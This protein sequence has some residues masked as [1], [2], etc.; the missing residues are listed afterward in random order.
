M[1]DMADQDP[2]HIIIIGAGLAGL[3]TAVAIKTANPS[4]AV[5]ILETTKSLSEIGAGLQLTPNGTLPKGTHHEAMTVRRYDGSKILNHIHDFQNLILKKYKSPFMGMHRV[6]FQRALADKCEELGVVLRLG[7]RVV[8]VDIESVFVKL[9]GGEVVD[10]DVIVSADGL[11]SL[12]RSVFLK[13]PSPPLP[14][15][16]LAYRIVIG[17]DDLSGDDA[18]ELTEFLRRKETNFWVGPETHVA[19]Y[20]VRDGTQYNIVLLCPD[21]LPEGI[22]KLDGDLVEMMGRFDG[23]D[24]I[25]RKFLGQVKRVQKWKLMHLDPLPEWTNKEGTFVMVGDACHPMLP[26]LAQ[27]ANSACEDAAVLGFLLGQVRSSTVEGKQ[28]MLQKVLPLYE[29]LRKTRGEGIVRATWDQREDFHMPDGEKQIARDK[30]WAEGE[31]TRYTSSKVG[32]WLFEY[33]AY[34]EVEDV[35]AREKGDDEGSSVS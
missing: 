19:G 32:D 8:D 13:T 16:D 34:K 5:T 28:R 12:A 22:S 11:W 9:E 26:Y 6:D 17:V 30:R 20:A 4:H 18:E 27:G 33:D 7:C 2:V 15:G 1:L 10:G 3:A 21:N 25:L 29:K 14:T 23:W 35:W 31:P 24:P